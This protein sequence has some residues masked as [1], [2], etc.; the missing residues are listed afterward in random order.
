ML[1]EMT[2][3]ESAIRWYPIVLMPSI[4]NGSPPVLSVRPDM[5]HVILAANSIPGPSKTDSTLAPPSLGRVLCTLLVNRTYRRENNLKQPHPLSSMLQDWPTTSMAV[6][7]WTR[8]LL[9][10]VLLA[11]LFSGP[12]NPRSPS[13][14]S[15]K[16]IGLRGLLKVIASYRS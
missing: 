8:G 12:R 11:F 4:Q 6:P 2:G 5:H 1:Q 15:F 3:K 10:S 16:T 13:S 14:G 7:T 9:G